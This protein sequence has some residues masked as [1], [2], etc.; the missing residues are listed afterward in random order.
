MSARESDEV[1]MH[2]K[3]SVG[4]LRGIEQ[5]ADRQGVFR[6]CALDH[7]GVV[8]HQ[9]AP[10]IAGDISAEQTA[11]KMELCQMLAPHC[12]AVLLDPIYGAGHAIASGAPGN[13]GLLVSVEAT[14][15]QGLSA[16]GLTELLPEWTV[17]KVKRMGAWAAKLLVFYCPEDEDLARR[18]LRVVEQ[19]ST[20]CMSHDLLCFV[21]PLTIPGP[22]ENREDTNSRKLHLVCA[23]ARAMSALAVDV[24]KAEFP[25]DPTVQ[26][27]RECLIAQCRELTQASRVPWVRLSGGVLFEPFCEQLELACRGG[28]SGFLAGRAIW[29]DAFAV[30]D[31]QERLR[32]LETVVASRLDRLAEI[33]RQHAT[34][35]HERMD[36]DRHISPGWYRTYPEDGP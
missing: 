24:L 1:K 2:T 9:I 25:G 12:G 26:K 28:A 3:L 7:V 4:K 22:G 5:V 29:A 18:Q 23:A 8:W 16:E 35:W 19:F 15:Y 14:G 20:E 21:E 11:F 17:K 32:F 10:N 27:D 6:I 13:I 30:T 34:P 33:A 31:R 36:V